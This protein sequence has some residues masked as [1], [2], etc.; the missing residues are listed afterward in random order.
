MMCGGLQVI[1]MRD[2]QFLKGFSHRRWVIIREISL[3]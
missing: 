3:F 2:R 1:F